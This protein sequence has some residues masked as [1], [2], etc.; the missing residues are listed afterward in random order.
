MAAQLSPT[1]A[2]KAHPQ[3][4]GGNRH[5]RFMAAPPQPRSPLPPPPLPGWGLHP[6]FMAGSPTTA[7]KAPPQS[8]GVRVPASWQPHHNPEG[9]PQSLKVGVP[10]EVEEVEG[11]T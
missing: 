7:Q 10:Q 11:P 6:R 3:N 5:P 4:P 1:T 2:Q 8:L 9:P